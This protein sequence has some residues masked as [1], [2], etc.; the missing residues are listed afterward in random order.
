MILR[1]ILFAFNIPEVF[2]IF[3]FKILGF[4]IFCNYIETTAA[5]KTIIIIRTNFTIAWAIFARIIIEIVT[6]FAFKTFIRSFTFFA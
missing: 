1:L 2:S 5:Y 3:L 4:K 6:F